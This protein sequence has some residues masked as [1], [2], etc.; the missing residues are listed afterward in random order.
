[1]PA[2]TA[3]PLAGLTVIAIEQAV[4][5]PF[6]SARLADAGARVIKIE[7]A[8]GDF[9]RGY[10][11]VA[12]GQSSYFVW[13]NRGK[14]SIVLDLATSKGKT[15]L[16]NL[17]SGADVLVHNLK[18]GALS[19]LGFGADELVHRHPRLINCGVS[20]YGDTGPLSERKA[21]DLL[22]QAESG[23]C[24]ITGGPE[25]PARVGISVVDIATGLTAYSAILEALISRS[26]TGKGAE[27]RVSMFDVMAEWLTVPLLH[28]E[29]GKSPKRIGLSHPSIA[30]Y[31]L[32]TTSDAARILISIQ[33]DREWRKF[34]EIVVQ[35]PEMGTDPR[36]STNVAR[37]KNRRETDRL[38]ANALYHLDS[39]EALEGLTNADIAFA[40]LN[41]MSGLSAHPHLRRIV[42]ETPGGAVSLPAPAPIFVDAPRQYGR[43]PEINSFHAPE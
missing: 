24:A 17:L 20:G 22:V 23:L 2:T 11:D 10:D 42:V 40:T 5:A 34:C 9:A 41:E 7:R 33:S 4:S 16:S 26:V 14:E 31:G 29:A 19:R 43:V 3:R 18:P 25:E 1:M 12:A 27:I 21:Y 6:C 36:F 37:V 39:K 32:F 38:V 30:P 13:L 8:E 28:E 15:T 35:K